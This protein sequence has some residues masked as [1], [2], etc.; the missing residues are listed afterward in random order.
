VHGN[1]NVTKKDNN[2]ARPEAALLPPVDV[3]EDATG[4]TLYADL[5]GV[6]KEKLNL[7]LG[8][9]RALSRHPMRLRQFSPRRAIAGRGPRRQGQGGLQKR[10]VAHRTT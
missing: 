5:P 10:R 2:P 3:I 8:N 4:I 9:G 1:T 7:Q 6:P